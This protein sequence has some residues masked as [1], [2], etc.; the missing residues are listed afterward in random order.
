MKLGLKLPSGISMRL[1]RYLLRLIFLLGLILVV[2]VVYLLPAS[3]ALGPLYGMLAVLIIA[4]VLFLLQFKRLAKVVGIAS[5]FLGL[6]VFVVMLFTSDLYYNVFSPFTH[7]VR[8]YP[9]ECKGKVI[10][11]GIDGGGLCCGTLSI[12]L[13]SSSY[14]VSVNRQQ[15]IHSSETEMGVNMPL[16]NC[17]VRDVFNWRCTTFANANGNVTDLANGACYHTE[18]MHDGIPDTY[19]TPCP[20]EK[21]DIFFKN[22]KR[23]SVY[24]RGREWWP[25]GMTH[26]WSESFRSFYTAGEEDCKSSTLDY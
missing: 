6:M 7:E 10:R 24:V 2:A 12:P 17:E 16:H 11:G 13:N 9:V 25:G 20:A 5:P 23:D 1:V 8:V 18:W 15:V 19:D 22:F 4:M 26:H 3:E 14:T 21:P